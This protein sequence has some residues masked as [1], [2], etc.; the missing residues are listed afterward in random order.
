MKIFFGR[1]AEIAPV[2]C[3][4][5]LRY[6]PDGEK[7]AAL[8]SIMNETSNANKNVGLRLFYPDGSVAYG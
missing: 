6:E 1:T 7:L 3:D 8:F 4:V 2:G 5:E